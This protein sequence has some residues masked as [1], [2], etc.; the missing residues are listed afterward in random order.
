MIQPK[1]KIKGG[2]CT[3][4]ARSAQ[5]FRILRFSLYKSCFTSLMLIAI[6]ISM[7]RCIGNTRECNWK[8]VERYNTR[9]AG[10]IVETLLVEIT[11]GF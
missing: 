4:L 9:D 3:T 11:F 6:V 8:T 1:E 5:V 10:L 7:N 2:Q